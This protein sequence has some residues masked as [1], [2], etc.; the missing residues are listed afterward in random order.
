MRI[1]VILA[2][3][4]TAWAGPALAQTAP[5]AARQSH[6][7]LAGRYLELTQGGDLMKQMR[8]QI[9]EGYGDSGLPVDQR[10][11]MVDNMTEM[12]ANVLETTILEVQDDVA[13][14]F[15]VQE[16]EAAIAFYESP[17][18]RSVV[19][20]QVDMNS[21]IQEVMMPLL[22]PRMTDLMEKFCL[23]FDCTALGAAAAK[24]DD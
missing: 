2:V 16:L 15:T 3:L 14:S 17:V 4:L 21:E 5:D 13:D 8:R 6:L 10:A 1:I 12:F 20:K 24:E 19:R 18:G 23:R 9:E 7:D 22:V 11:W